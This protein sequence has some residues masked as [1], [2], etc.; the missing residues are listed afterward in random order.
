MKL[1]ITKTKILGLPLIINEEMEPGRVFC[2]DGTH[3]A[4]QTGKLELHCRR[5]T[6]EK[7]LSTPELRALVATMVA[8]VKEALAR[9]RRDAFWTN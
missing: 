9:K 6:Y 7:V 4:S 1:E 2:L 5:A 3:E 8:R